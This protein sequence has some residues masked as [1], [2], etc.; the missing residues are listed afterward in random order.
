[1]ANLDY[2]RDTDEEETEEERLRRLAGGMSAAAPFDTSTP[3]GRLLA[4]GATSQPEIPEKPPKEAVES[5]DLRLQPVDSATAPPLAGDQ[6][7]LKPLSFRE[8]QSLPQTTP[9]VT[10]GSAAWEQNRLQRLEDQKANPW[11]SAENHPGFGGRLAH[12]LAKVGNVAGEI[13]APNVMANIPGTE[14]HRE[15][16]EAAT[17]RRLGE[18]QTRETSA[19]NVAG[20][21]RLRQ[22]QGENIESEKNIREAKDEESIEKDAQGN[23]VGYKDKTGKLHGLDEPDTPQGVKDI[24]EATQNKLL[25]QYKQDEVTGNIVALKYDPKTGQTT[26]DV[27]YKGSPKV[28]TETRT[29]LDPQGKPHDYVYDITPNSPQFGK[30]LADLG[31]TKIPNNAA[32]QEHAL[33]WVYGTDKNGKVQLVPKSDADAEGMTHI[34]KASDKDYNDAKTHTTVLNDMQAKL[35]D[36][37]AS[38]KALDQGTVQ[39][40]II[41]SALR[42]VEKNTTLGQM[43]DA[44]L[45]KGAT[46]ETQEYIQS[47]LSL[48]ESA[49]GLPK[50]I[51]GGSRVQ[52]IQASA[53]WATTPGGASLNGDYALRQSKKFQANIDRLRE[54]NPGVRGLHIED[55]H[56]DILSQGAAGG[57]PAVPKVGDIVDGHRFKGG[58]PAKKESWEKAS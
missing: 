50:E 53:L 52:E 13:V 8:R 55:V 38:R 18:A 21:N 11:G 56:P 33:E 10:A 24:A 54:R 6:P 31:E 40:A 5:P 30:R 14:L 15:A 39:R 12:V 17:L 29:I 28:K 2:L 46:P 9:G 7:A 22:I 45:M 44:G 48:R 58:D 43:T 16:D 32:A 42:T 4:V 19:A 26:S 36:V 3:R 23:V 1:M 25:P 27:V 49:L 34:A 51:T 37:V 41:A 20:E 35:N 57:A 47:V